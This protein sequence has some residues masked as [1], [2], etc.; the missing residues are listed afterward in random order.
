MLTV[1]W[2]IGVCGVCVSSGR[3][4]GFSK[5]LPVTMAVGVYQIFG[6]SDLNSRQKE[7]PDV[8]GGR[9]QLREQHASIAAAVSDNWIRFPLRSVFRCGHVLVLLLPWS[10]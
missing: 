6:P 9:H 7:S 1:Y 5:A 8:A 10:C 3:F 2:P 4:S